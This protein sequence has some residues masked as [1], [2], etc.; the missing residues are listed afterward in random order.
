MRMYGALKKESGLGKKGE[1]VRE[2]E[3]LMGASIEWQ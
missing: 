2:E 3:R 1:W